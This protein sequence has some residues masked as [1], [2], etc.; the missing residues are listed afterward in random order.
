MQAVGPLLKLRDRWI[1]VSILALGLV[2]LMGAFVYNQGLRVPGVRCF[3]QA[4]FGVPSP[5]CGMTRSFMAIARGDLAQAFAYHLFGPLLFVGFAIA[6]GHAT[7]ELLLGRSLTAPYL[8]LG[9]KPW[10]WVGLA[11]AVLAYYA[12]RLLVRYD[13]LVPP[14]A[15]QDSI[16][17]Q[18]FATG[19][20]A[21]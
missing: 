8:K 11:V 16:I 21:I 4:T 7:T 6:V 13:V 15:I 5:G 14:T 3:F 20:Q 18:L 2:P 12:L 1:R 9:Q 10:F 19:A 17:W